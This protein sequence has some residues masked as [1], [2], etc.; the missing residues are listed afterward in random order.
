[1]PQE[2]IGIQGHEFQAQ[3]SEKRAAA[4]LEALLLGLMVKL[5]Q[6]LEDILLYLIRLREG[7]HACLFQDVVLGHL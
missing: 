1:M 3:T 7:F 5:L 6:Q 2:Y 4:P